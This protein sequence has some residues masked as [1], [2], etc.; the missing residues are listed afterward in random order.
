MYIFLTIISYEE[1]NQF[2]LQFDTVLGDI[3]YP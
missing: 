1:N 2:L 3:K